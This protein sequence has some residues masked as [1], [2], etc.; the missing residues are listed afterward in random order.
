[1][2]DA[3]KRLESNVQRM[4]SLAI[5]NASDVLRLKDAFSE[6]ENMLHDAMM[7]DCEHGVSSLN[8]QA[9]AEYLKQYPATEKA[10]R[11]TLQIIRATL[12]D[13]K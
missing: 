3:I 5:D 1:M 4:A 7:S 6:I 2:T 9:A 8:K 12:G 13:D 11:E 10:I